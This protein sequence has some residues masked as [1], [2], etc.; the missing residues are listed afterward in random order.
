MRRTAEFVVL[1]RSQ[2]NKG[3]EIWI[4]NEHVAV[5]IF[6]PPEEAK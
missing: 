1:Q 3:G 5:L 6:G 4:K 2:M